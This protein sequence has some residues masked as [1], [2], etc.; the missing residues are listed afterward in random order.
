MN[1]I[2]KELAAI[3]FLLL[4]IPPDRIIAQINGEINYTLIHNDNP[5]RTSD[6]SQDYISSYSAGLNY[7]PWKEKFSL[8]YAFELND[9]RNLS[10]KSYNHHSLGFS[11]SFKFLNAREEEN[12]SVGGSYLLKQNNSGDELY[13]YMAYSVSAKGHFYFLDNLLFAAGYKL[14]NKN[15]PSLYDLTYFDNSAYSRLSVFFE[16]NTA[17]HLEAQL[18]N[19]A[20]SINN[21]YTLNY[22]SQA[23]GNR[24]GKMSRQE[25]EKSASVTQLLTTFKIS[26]TVFENT[27]INFYYSLRSSLNKSSTISLTEFMYSDD[28]DLWDDPF[29]F[30]SNNFGSEL[31]QILPWDMALRIS[32][33]YSGRRYTENLAASLSNSQRTDKRTEFWIGLSKELFSIPFISSTVFG[34]EYMHITNKSSEASFSYKN[35]LLL[36]SA[37]ISF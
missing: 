3:L 1:K 6:G 33:E 20:Y 25:D 13:K 28:E 9:F 15:Y 26:K 4:V 2:I 27:G 7:Q 31:L 29:S 34:L 30:Q 21:L 35:N 17:L 5:Y 19:R 36:L 32:A 12:V 14:F 37:G 10:E 22:G 18:G 16:T 8:S 24:K 11:Y 23:H